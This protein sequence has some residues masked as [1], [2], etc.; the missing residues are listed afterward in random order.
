MKR[1]FLV[2]GEASGD[3]HGAELAKALIALDPGVEIHASGGAIL[4]DIVKG[5]FVHSAHLNATG[6]T[7]VL[8]LL[9]QYLKLFKEVRAA[10]SRARPDLVVFIDNPGFN[11]RLAQRLLPES[12]PMVYYIPPQIW[13]WGE[14]RI[15][16]IKRCFKKVFVVFRFEED[17]YRSRGMPAVWVG[18]PLKDEMPEAARKETAGATRTVLL[19]PGSRSNEVKTLFPILVASAKLI[20]RGLPGTRFTFIPS[21]SLDR[22]AYEPHLGRSAISIEPVFGDKYDAM[23]SSDLA[24]AC[25]GTVTLECALAGLPMIIVNRGSL[26]TYLFVRSVL[27]V[28]YLGLPNLLANA[29][30]VPELMQYNCTASKIAREAVDILQKPERARQMRKD[31]ALAMEGIGPAGA[32]KRA[33]QEILGLL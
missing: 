6:I 21:P 11:M 13:G 8:R 25:S 29:P 18:H 2:A 33:A 4:R 32:S 16:T 27:R 28:I 10:I 7:A 14:K 17:Y 5:E 12:I 15:E 26:L 22:R 31:M 24:V 1:I 19:L 23:R 30:I 9:P 20:A 3:V